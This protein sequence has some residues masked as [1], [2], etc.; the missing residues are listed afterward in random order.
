MPLDFPGLRG[1]VEGKRIYG[2]VAEYSRASRT[3][4][5]QPARINAGP[6]TNL[7]EGRARQE[8]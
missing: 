7:R 8:I 2:P 1:I 3:K 5:P 4:T 6:N